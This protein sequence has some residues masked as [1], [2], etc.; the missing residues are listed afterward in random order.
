MLPEAEFIFLLCSERSGSN[1]ITRIFDAHPRV[2]GPSPTHLGSD[3]LGNLFR[4]DAI[5]AG[6]IEEFMTDFLDLFNAKIGS[7]QSILTREELASILLAGSPL[8]AYLHLY[9]T[10]A[11]ANGKPIVFIKENRLYEWAPILAPVLD[12]SR[13]I[14]VCRDPRD[15]ALSWKKA[16][17]L[18]GGV[19]R[20]AGIW[21]EDQMGFARLRAELQSVTGKPIPCL[22]YERL[23]QKPVESLSVVCAESGLDFDTKMLEFHEVTCS[24]PGAPPVAE[25]QNLARPLMTGNSGKFREELSADEI[26]YVETVCRE[27]IAALGYLPDY[28]FLADNECQAMRQR[29]E[30]FEPL[31]KP[32]YDRLP[33]IE[34]LKR[35]RQHEVFLRIRNR[36][37]KIT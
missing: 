13:F 6:G 3:L 25:W 14:Y 12:R 23:L 22:T 34:R 24:P 33:E 7:W 35:C 18:R 37:W 30:T 4:Y 28:P 9:Q 1:L 36:P 17:A 27:S 2:C 26:R 5:T 29:L 10:E 31:H 19:V 8:D 32:S 20:A 16:P 15:M 11:R 21:A